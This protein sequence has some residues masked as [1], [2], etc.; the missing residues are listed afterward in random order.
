MMLQN[1]RLATFLTAGHR[2]LALL[3]L[4]AGACLLSWP[5]IRAAE[6]AR[7]AD[8]ASAP[9]TVITAGPEWIP[10]RPELEIE[11]GS[12]LD[13]SGMGFVDAPAGKHGPVIARADG[14]FAFTDSPDTPRRLWSEFCF[15]ART[16][17]MRKPTV[18]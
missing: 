15:G 17:L 14:Q 16:C 3:G 6:A 9:P 12:A 4:T 13:F 5:E 8:A 11:P 10:L 1:L 7:E 18:G 2:S